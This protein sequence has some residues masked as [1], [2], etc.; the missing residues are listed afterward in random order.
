MA[1]YLDN[2]GLSYLWGKIKSLFVPQT[3][4]VNGKALSSDITLTAE[5][6]GAPIE[7]I[8]N[9]DSTNKT[10]LRSLD[11]GTYVLKGYFTSFAGGTESYT[12]S[13]G[14]LVAVVKTASVSYVQILY[15]KGN[16]V[17]YLEITDNEVTRN[18]AKLTIM[19][20]TAN[21]VTDINAESDDYSYPSAK[22]VYDTANGKLD[23][24]G[25]TMTGL[26]TLS[27]A[28][29]ANL[30]AA[31]KA[32]VDNKV[33]GQNSETWTFTLESGSTVTKTVVLK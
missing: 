3:R 28:P 19:E 26:L 17:Q 31:T 33:S 20:T 8:E 16:T 1:K 21:K 13:T 4:T 10:A 22:A 18:D 30:H 32:Y 2:T 27:G 23:K 9:N 14:M 11:S 29:T 12:F 5:D 24:S 7:L 15:A 25:G 6:V